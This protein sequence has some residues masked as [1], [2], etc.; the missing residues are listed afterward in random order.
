MSLV[1]LEPL[2]R[3]RL[4][5]VLAVSLPMA[6]V[7]RR[8]AFQ[9]TRR[10]DIPRLTALAEAILPTL[11]SRADVERTVAGFDR[12][13]GGYRA[14]AELLHRYGAS[15]IVRTPPSPAPRWAAQLDELDREA[16]R[17]H[18]RA[19]A[20]VDREQ[21][22]ALVAAAIAAERSEGLPPVVEARHL[23]VALLSYWAGSTGAFDLAYRA[24]IN[25]LA[26]RPLAE[27]PDRPRAL[28]GS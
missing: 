13:L 3:R 8:R 5:S 27:N 19:Y 15:E 23:A 7:L 25:R 16:Q 14:G 24:R 20:A 26:C 21:R 11:L 10:L 22:R 2:P 4:L 28:E 9:A 1:A 12:W 18:G 6:A 17:Q